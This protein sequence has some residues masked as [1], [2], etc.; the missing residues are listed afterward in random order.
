V[1]RL[2]H[3]IVCA[4]SQPPDPLRHGR[5]LGDHDETKVGQHSRDT[6][7]VIPGLGTQSRRVHHQGLQLHRDELVRRNAS[8]KNPV[9]PPGDVES[10]GEDPDEA[11]V[12][13][14][15][16]EPDCA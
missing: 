5:A 7:E 2:V 1:S 13:V 4:Q 15:D 8:G 14:E 12:P 3:E 9:L 6:L 11:G 10:L 16:R